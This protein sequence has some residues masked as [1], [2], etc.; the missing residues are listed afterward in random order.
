MKAYFSIGNNLLLMKFAFGKRRRVSRNE[1]GVTAIEYAILAPVF[2]SMVI[3]TLNLSLALH[4]ANTAKWAVKKAARTLLVTN[5]MDEDAIQKLIN[6]RI[7][8]IHPNMDLE[9]SY[10]LDSSG[11]LP[12]GRISATYVH[13][14]TVPLVSTFRARFPIEVNVPR[15][16]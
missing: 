6:E 3:G 15:T 7:H 16:S 2:V 4:K 14:V 9:I 12:I 8:A 10:K 5:D 1:D 13:K 11:S